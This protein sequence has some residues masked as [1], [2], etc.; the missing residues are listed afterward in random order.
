VV[1]NVAE[2]GRIPSSSMASVNWLT[3]GLNNFRQNVQGELSPEAAADLTSRSN[4]VR[5]ASGVARLTAQ[6]CNRGT[7]PVGAGIPVV[8]RAGGA[9]ACSTV[10]GA[11]LA[12]GQC[13]DVQCDWAHPPA[14]AP[15]VDVSVTVGGQGDLYECR[16]DNNTASIKSVFCRGS[17][18]VTF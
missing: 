10:T 9:V 17:G 5:C 7:K 16:G 2:D 13:A 8:M 11:E 18:G 3:K 4:D 12:P 6:A 1:T 14:M 15:G